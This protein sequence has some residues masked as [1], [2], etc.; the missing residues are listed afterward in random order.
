[1]AKITIIR[2]LKKLW[3]AA[4]E[5]L[6]GKQDKLRAGSNIII[7]G[8]TISAIIDAGFI[9]EIVQSVPSRG[10]ANTIYFVPVTGGTS[11]NVYDEYMFIN[12]A[13]EKIGSTEIDLSNY[14]NKTQVDNLLAGKQGTLTAGANIN[15]TNNTIKAEGY[16]YNPTTGAIT[17]GDRDINDNGSIRPK[18]SATGVMAHA[19]GSGTKAIG[20][21]SHVEGNGG[22]ATGIQSHAEGSEGNAKG[23]NSHVEGRQAVTNGYAS[24]AEGAITET[25]GDYAS[26]TTNPK[27]ADSRT[28]AGD[29]AHAEGNACIAYGYDSHAEGRKTFAKGSQSHAEGSN[30]NAIGIASHSEGTLTTASGT[31]SH[32]EGDKTT[33]SGAASHAEGNQ[34]IARGETS[35]VEGYK[36]ETLTGASNC[37]AE[38]GQSKCNANVIE[39]HAEGHACEVGGSY[40]SNTKTPSSNTNAGSFAHAEGNATIANGVA[41]HAEGRLTLA[42]GNNSHAE[43]ASSVANNYNAHAEGRATKALCNGEHA[44]G[45]YNV[46]HHTTDSFDGNAGNTVHSTGIGAD[47]NTRKNAVEVMQN[48]DAYLLGVGNYDGIHIKGQSGAPT[49]LRTLQEVVNGLRTDL[50]NGLNECQKTV[51]PYARFDEVTG[52]VT[53]DYPDEDVSYFEVNYIGA[54]SG[55]GGRV[56][57]VRPWRITELITNDNLGVPIELLLVDPMYDSVDEWYANREYIIRVVCDGADGNLSV[58]SSIRWATP[59]IHRDLAEQQFGISIDDYAYMPPLRDGHTYDIHI[60]NGV[61][62]WVETPNA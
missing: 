8:N 61:A 6:A 4:T 25:G 21:S 41:A 51:Y 3:N 57:C 62:W 50:E 47:D 22:S 10:L 5:L 7:N 32:A 39:G 20:R 35:H 43:G 27:T 19:E 54:Y 49:G 24:H 38:G 60:L 33:A 15:I 28:D 9:I 40:T 23:T 56:V 18:P 16:V 52:E 59:Q 45:S 44:E 58:P 42:R 29:Y 11:P 46:S 12:G 13:I 2:A 48:G 53:G 34:S 17:D 14:Y 30:T 55:N 31:A 36:C 37:H 26:A 1:M